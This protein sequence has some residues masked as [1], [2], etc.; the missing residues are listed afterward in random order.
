LVQLGFIWVVQ[1]CVE[2]K[3][4]NRECGL[5]NQVKLVQFRQREIMFRQDLYRKPKVDR[6][7]TGV[8]QSHGCM[9]LLV[10]ED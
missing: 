2:I 9:G 1:A 7:G 5:D 6:W 10:S 8:T 4:L 3:A